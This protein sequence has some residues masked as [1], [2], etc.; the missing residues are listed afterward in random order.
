MGNLLS[1]IK[2]EKKTC[3]IICDLN[4]NILNYQEQTHTGDCSRYNVLVYVVTII[5]II[6]AY[7]AARNIA[8][9]PLYD[10]SPLLGRRACVGGTT[11]YM[12][13]LSALQRDHMGCR[14]PK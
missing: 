7:D 2:T 12:R 11:A 14:H 1:I 13:Q 4:I 6:I 8:L 3:Y 9:T 10:H 5:I